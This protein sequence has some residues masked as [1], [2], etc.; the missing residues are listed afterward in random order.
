MMIRYADEN[1]FDELR[2]HDTHIEEQELRNSIKAN[3]ILL[4]LEHD[5]LIG[6]LRYGLFWDNIPFINMLYFMEEHRGKGNGRQL[7][8]FWE[9]EM[10]SKQYKM[11]MTSTLS[12]EQAQF[13]Y[14]KNGYIDCGS[15]LLP[16]EPLEIMMLKKLM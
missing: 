10:R 6:W 8:D 9:N 14:R 7:V 12:N 3:R 2:K 15:L 1:D 13:F 16:N 11:V 5:I 4:M